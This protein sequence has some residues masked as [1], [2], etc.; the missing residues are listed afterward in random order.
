[1]AGQHGVVCFFERSV[2]E[3]H[4]GV[5]DVFVQ[6]AAAFENDMGH[7]G[8]ILIEEDGEFLSVKFFGNSGETANVAE[9]YGDFGL[10]RFDELGIEQQAANNFRAEVLTEGGA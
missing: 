2:P 10:A 1:M 9:H 8:K 6:G 7:I 4:H 5:T 3:S